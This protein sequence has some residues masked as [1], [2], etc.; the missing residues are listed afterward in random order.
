VDV[1]LALVAALLFALGTVLQ[2]RADQLLFGAWLVL[3]AVWD[4]DSR[5][6]P[7]V[8]NDRGG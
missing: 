7:P 3:L 4:A 5:R 6:A 2:Q 8:A 1:V